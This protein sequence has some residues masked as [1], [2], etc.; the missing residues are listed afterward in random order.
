MPTYS[1]V[2]KSFDG[3]NRKGL[4]DAKNKKELASLLKQDG[5]RRVNKGVKKEKEIFFRFKICFF[6]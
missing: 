5:F 4:A 2:A 3:K 1:Y 6:D